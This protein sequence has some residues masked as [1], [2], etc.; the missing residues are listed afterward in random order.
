MR[1]GMPLMETLARRQSIRAFSERPLPQ[2]TLANLLWAA[3]GI[4]RQ[5]GEDR[6]APSWRHSKE[7]DIYVATAD[8]VYVYDPKL[9]SLRRILQGDI[10]KKT[11][12]MVFVANAPVVLIY[13]ADRGRM[14]KAPV[15]EQVLNAH[16]DSGVIAQNVYLYAASAG[17][18]T[19]VLGS[20]DRTG[21]AQALGLKPDQ[22]VTFSQPV[23]FPK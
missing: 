17:L 1:G 12:S 2:Q 22:I 5:E 18:G 10:R 19:V 6:T 9:N 20:V 16:V 3:F 8:G 11:S 23:G 21:L 13:V 7:T 14:A 4:N 15:E